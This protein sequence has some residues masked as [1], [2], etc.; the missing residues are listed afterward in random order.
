MRPFSILTA[1]GGTDTVSN[2]KNAFAVARNAYIDWIT[3]P[4]M[5]LFL[6]VIMIMINSYVTPLLNVAKYGV[7]SP[8]NAFEA[9]L[10]VCCEPRIVSTIFSLFFIVLICD[11]PKTSANDTFVLVRT[12]KINWIAGQVLFAF[13]AAF[14][15]IAVM[16]TA[17]TLYTAPS[18]F[19]SNGWSTVTRVLDEDATLGTTFRLPAGVYSTMFN[20]SS[21]MD[22][23]FN[24]VVLM[25][26]NFTALAMIILLF[27]LKGKKILGIVTAGTVV[28]CGWLF[29]NIN[30]GVQWLFPM[31]HS[32][33]TCHNTSVIKLVPLWQ[34]YVYF[35]IVLAAFIALAVMF[36]D[37][38]SFRFN[39]SSNS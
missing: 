30:S 19:F 27:N 13:F 22:A 11:F 38:Y 8:L 2:I 39:D 36:I 25:M 31:S 37:K 10:T 17:I 21:P 24:S 15:Y 9:F 29:K 6:I 18:S 4:R 3:N 12:S 1:N 35:L 34:S 28:L 7:N 32:M 23:L 33:I 16:F 20:H 14:S 5:F 26:L